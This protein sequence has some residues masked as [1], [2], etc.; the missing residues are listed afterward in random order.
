MKLLE[1][2]VAIITGGSRGIGRTIVEMFAQQGATVVFTYAGSVEKAQ[3]LEHTLRERGFIVKAL[4]SDASS[5][6]LAQA[7]IDETVKEFGKVDILINNA[8]ITRDNLLLRMTEEQWD[9]VMDNNLKSVFNY[10][11]AVIKTMLKQKD[12]VILNIS[13]VVGISGNAG[14]SNYSASKAGMIGFS[15]SIAKELGSRNIRV[16]VVA[17]GFIQTE[18]TDNLPEEE[19]K[20]WLADVPL[21][22]AGQTA[23]IANACV[24]LSSNMATYITGQVIQIDGGMLMG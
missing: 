15:K 16:N 1:G 20:K 6:S 17:P 14:Q 13:S 22:R 5:M 7:V 9:I 4:Q 23:D 8:G 24:F 12:G 18:M 21:N 2:K 11:K 10:T 19:L 3:S